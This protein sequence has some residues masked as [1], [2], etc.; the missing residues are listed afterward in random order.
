LWARADGGGE[1][2]TLVAGNNAPTP[3]S[4]SPD[5]TR[6]A[7]SEGGRGSALKGSHIWMLP[8]DLRDPEHPKPQ[9]PELF[10]KS[11][12]GAAQ[13]AFSPDGRW[14]A[15]VAA[16]PGTDLPEVWVRAFPDK[17]DRWQLSTG[18]GSF[19]IWSRT[20]SQLF[21]ENRG[22]DQIMVV[23]YSITGGT[24][25]AGKPR[26]WSDRRP[27]LPSGRQNIDLAPDGDHFAILDRPVSI[28]SAATHP[29][30][31]FNFFDELRR[32]A[33]EGK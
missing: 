12:P 17:G 8:L 4:F 5:G 18:G 6:L 7:Y 31:L 29:T 28:T 32:R 11:P 20:R 27:F 25:A 22:G 9:K 15:Y 14:I 3:F 21:F 30:F 19:P 24:F 23:D 2:Q 26:P 1:P 16:T 33:P 10:V 13:P